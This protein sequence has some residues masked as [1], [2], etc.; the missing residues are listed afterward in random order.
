MSGDA[1]PMPVV[2]SENALLTDAPVAIALA[3]A[4]SSSEES[5]WTGIPRRIALAEEAIRSASEIVF[6]ETSRSF[7]RKLSRSSPTAA[8]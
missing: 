4:I 1:R 7:V 6:R 5:S 8:S 3:L 2:I